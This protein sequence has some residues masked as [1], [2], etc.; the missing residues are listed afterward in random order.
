[1]PVAQT[2]T[3][4]AREYARA[5]YRVLPLYGLVYNEETGERECAC[6]DRGDCKSPGKHPYE[7]VAPR[8]AHDATADVNAIDAWPEHCNLGIVPPPTTA[9]IDIDDSDLA[10]KILEMDDIQEMCVART[11]RGI[12]LYVRCLPAQTQNLK[13]ADGHHVGEIRVDNAL[14]VLPPSRHLTGE[15]AW[16][17]RSLLTGVPET[18]GTA[19]DYIASILARVGV[20]LVE[21][22][23]P[24]I[25]AQQPSKI[26]EQ[27]LPFVVD[28]NMHLV[29]YQMLTG[30]YPT[31]DRS[32][33]LYQLGCEMYRAAAEL[34]IDLPP[35][36]AAGVIRKADSVAWRKFADR[37]DRDVRYWETAVKTQAEIAAEIAMNGKA[38]SPSRAGTATFAWDPVAG[39]TYMGG[40]QNPTPRRVCNFE[41]LIVEVQDVIG[42]E[43]DIRSD[44]F[45]RFT[46]V[47]GD[48]F[49][50]KLR[51]R[52]R[53]ELR[54]CLSG[55]LPPTFIVSS[56]EWGN[57][58]EGMR[59]YS[60][61]KLRY[62][63]VY[64]E[65]GWLPERDAFLLPATG[66]AIT[67]AGIDT[68]IELANDVV[69][70]SPLLRQYGVGMV[71]P[72]PGFDPAE[73]LRAL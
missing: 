13:A 23:D 31:P 38:S 26:V 2:T 15:Y 7:K 71:T 58:D 45:V 57:F 62:R 36:V 24:E 67:A 40:G 48:V 1:M 69:T 18:A 37:A 5:G 64:G 9:G 3:D 47:D 12:H 63:R 42:E 21:R 29:L 66:G 14:L 35:E 22:I 11:R 56:R 70:S 25:L 28:P 55:I 44:W 46:N 49:E 4:V 10:Q 51:E 54:K 33:I 39:F 59:W 73:A 20:S 16:I 17:G 34:G 32:K 8:G 61:D 30:T 43:G 53:A 27:D 60:K 68:T 19:F 72:E 6:K 41:P 65:T 52:E 50:T